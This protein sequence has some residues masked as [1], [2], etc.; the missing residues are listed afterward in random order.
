MRIKGLIAYIIFTIQTV[1]GSNP[2]YTHYNVNKGLPSN[3]VYSVF[4]DSKKFLWF[5]TESGVARYDG[6][7]YRYFSLGEGIPDAD[8]F[9]V[10]EDHLGR[11]W[12]HTVNGQL[13][14]YLNNKIYNPSNDTLC[15][16]IST[17]SI[18]VDIASIDNYL[19]FISKDEISI[20]VGQRIKKLDINGIKSVVKHNDTLVVFRTLGSILITD[21]TEHY[22]ESS[23]R[24]NQHFFTRSVNGK[25]HCLIGSELLIYSGV[26]DTTAET[27]IIPAKKDILLNDVTQHKH[28]LYLGTIDGLYVLDDQTY[29][30]EDSLFKGHNVSHVNIDFEGGFWISTLR[31]GTY[32]VKDLYSPIELHFKDLEG[33][34][35]H[36]VNRD[37]NGAIW[38]GLD[39]NRFKV[40]RPNKSPIEF[41]I[42]APG[43]PKKARITRI[44]HTDSCTYVLAKLF[45]AKLVNYKVV[46]IIGSGGNDF[47]FHNRTVYVAGP[48]FVNDITLNEKNKFIRDNREEYLGQRSNRIGKS[49]TGLIVASTN[50]VYTYDFSK[51][52]KVNKMGKAIVVDMSENYLLTMDGCLFHKNQD[53]RKFKQ[54]SDFGN[55]SIFYCIYEKGRKLYLGS[56]QGLYELDLVDS[57]IYHFPQTFDLSV[58]SICWYD[59]D[60]LMGTDNG[61]YRINPNSKQNILEPPSLNIENVII[62]GV[63]LPVQDFYNLNSTQR[64]ISIQFIGISYKSN[65]SYSYS[66]NDEDWIET[67]SPNLLLNLDPGDYNIKISSINTAGE[68]YSNRIIKELKFS[69]AQPLWLKPWFIL[70]CFAILLIVVYVIYA[71]NLRRIK[72]QHVLEEQEKEQKMLKILNEKTILELEHKALRMQMNPHFI[73]NAINTIKGFYLE[74]K[75]KD[76]S[77]YIDHFSKLLRNIL[78]TPQSTV[79]L[80]KELQTLEKYVAMAKM[81]FPKLNY[82]VTINGDLDATKVLIPNML[83]QPF[84]ENS[85]I[86]GLAPKSGAGT[87]NVEISRD[88]DLIK[89]RIIDDGVGIKKAKSRHAKKSLSLK[90]TKQ[91]LQ[92]INNSQGDELLQIRELETGGAELIIKTKYERI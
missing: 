78:E 7:N 40:Y 35:I 37:K 46:D 23:S 73:F 70:T 11:I 44:V 62:N 59:G 90:L 61:L 42:D 51:F 3:T 87:I 29:T 1:D 50:G 82:K 68:F 15:S 54:V 89:F 49:K 58:K 39:E 81:R 14:Y 91:R 16:R 31:L 20:V 6:T 88:G 80:E 21:T 22:R 4:E 86:H 66:I 64:N 75:F 28:K 36:I 13:S 79:S 72:G 53:F 76:A 55:V 47:I 60:L 19:Y 9:R 48:V 12:F 57:V 45:L 85:I 52:K 65:P 77:K 43:T 25:I 24:V 5:C 63:Y 84:V 38:V 10:T 8:V 71:L 34:A 33:E 67:N 30:V 26:K 2:I 92:M 32:Y 69:I 18:I 74:G 56:V 41:N 17:S 27:V 83:L